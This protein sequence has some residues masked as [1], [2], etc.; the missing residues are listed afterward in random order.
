MNKK[1]DRIIFIC[2]MLGFL[3]VAATIALMQ[4]LA[5]TPPLYGNPPDEHARFLVP[6][7]IYEHGVIPTGFEE[8]IRIPAYGFSYG[9]YN[10]FPYIVQGYVMRFVGLFT[11]SMQHLLYAARFVNVITG[12]LMAGVVY[13]LSGKLFEK[14]AFRWIFCFGIMFLPQSLFMHT[15]VNTDSMCLLSTAMMVYAWVGAYRDGYN[16]AN[17]LWLAGG[18]ILCALSYYNAYGY[19]LSSMLLFAAY[20][21]QKKEGKW[22]FDW[23]ELLKKGIFIAALVLLGIGWWFIRSYIVNDGDL[24]GLATR[25]KMAIQYAIPEVNPLTMPTF[26]NKGYT[27]WE[28]M[29][30][31][32][33]LEGAFYSF[34]AAF[35]SMSIF[36]SQWMYRAYKVFFA[37][38]LLACLVLRGQNRLCTTRFPAEKPEGKKDWFHEVF[39]HANMILCILIP[40]FLLIYYAYTMDYQNQGR[41]LLPAIIPLFY[42]VTCGLQKLTQLKWVPKWLINTGVGLAIALP[43]SST[44]WMLIKSIEVYM[45]TGMVM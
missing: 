45:Q 30:E 19:I 35:G 40:V 17:S 8:E 9:I 26:Q 3:A 4:P 20:F 14:S 33:F 36:G 1:A 38:A 37:A 6:R 34:V 2:Y 5:D 32:N 22:Y 7:Y 39:F 23:K 42:Y 21:L 44:V 28:M 43:V 16:R 31:K 18:I 12:C 11:D 41:Y 29:E 15:Y 27:V 10:V 24:L 13:L 25:E